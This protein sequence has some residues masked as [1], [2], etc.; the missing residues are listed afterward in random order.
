[1]KKILLLLVAFLIIGCSKDEDTPKTIELTIKEKLID[2]G[3]IGFRHG[4]FKQYK[5]ENG[6]NVL[7]KEGRLNCYAEGYKFLKFTGP[8]YLYQRNQGYNEINDPY[9]IDGDL[10]IFSMYNPSSN[11]VLD[12]N[13]NDCSNYIP[14]P[15]TK[16]TNRFKF[17]LIDKALRLETEMEYSYYNND[18]VFVLIFFYE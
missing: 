10:L 3:E 5:V 4:E 15:V 18:Y 16:F 13:N 17:S 11:T 8:N 6:N 9:I 7:I 14:L 12:L 1:M 2:L